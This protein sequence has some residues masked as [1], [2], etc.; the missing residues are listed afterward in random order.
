MATLP[1]RAKRQQDKVRLPLRTEVRVDKQRAL[2][3]NLGR[4]RLPSR[5]FAGH[6]VLQWWG[7][8]VAV[9]YM[10]YLIVPGS[11]RGNQTTTIVMAGFGILFVLV[12]LL[13]GRTT[14]Y[15]PF[16][17]VA[18]GMLQV[19]IV[20]SYLIIVPK[21]A[22]DIPI[23]RH[24]YWPILLAI[25]FLVFYSL[26]TLNELWRKRL[27]NVL[28]GLAALHAFVGL[29]Q[30]FKLP[31]FK[32]QYTY[33][34]QFVDTSLGQAWVDA[35]K[36]RTVG[37]GAHAYD[38]SAMCILG[39][40]LCAGQ[41]MVRKLKWWEV[42]VMLLCTMALVTAQ[43]RTFYFTW[44]F[45][46]P[47]V[48]YYVFKRDKKQGMTVLAMVAIGMTILLGLF[49]HQLEY[50]LRGP[51]TIT[52]SRI[53]NWESANNII[54]EFPATGIG[55][56]PGVMGNGNVL[57][58]RWTAMYTESGYRLMLVTSGFPGFMILLIMVFGT[59]AGAFGLMR[60]NTATPERRVAAFA[61]FIYGV[62]I[63][64]LLLVTN[65]LGAETLTFPAAF[66]LGI[67]APHRKEKIMPVRNQFDRLRRA[68]KSIKRD[69]R[70]SG[71]N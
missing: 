33:Y 58:S 42:S 41:L 29:G 9:A 70:A 8:I 25:P 4:D 45:T 57:P 20:A 40:A 59:I 48:L 10:L 53:N 12:S 51:N 22:Q 2:R 18:L 34:S 6:S 38:L 66:I 67:V 19:W 13:Y 56:N 60:M 31:G 24:L 7:L 26:C 16:P 55:P 61:G 44:L 63:S 3:T 21:I 46:A 68:L 71:W 39:I 28:I 15:L 27:I 14:M 37:L 32:W 17:V 62:S 65:C 1:G 36:D 64:I 54:A 52:G 23:G 35:N 30:F 47:F 49:Q 69:P 11:I 50:G 5:A 43:S